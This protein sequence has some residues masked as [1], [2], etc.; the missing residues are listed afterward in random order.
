MKKGNL[1]F[2]HLHTIKTN[3]QFQPFP[4]NFFFKE[5][6]FLERAPGGSHPSGGPHL[7][8]RAS[9][10]LKNKKKNIPR[11]QRVNLDPGEVEMNPGEV[12]MEPSGV[13]N[14]A[15]EKLTERRICIC[16][17]GGGAF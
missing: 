14:L 5:S 15:I 10:L 6:T 4:F 16:T 7:A 9:F 3:F 8:G 2:R 11:G 12:E 17:R 13:E 1:F